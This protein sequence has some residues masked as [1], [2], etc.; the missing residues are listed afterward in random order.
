MIVYFSK[1]VKIDH[2][3]SKKHAMEINEYHWNQWYWQVDRLSKTG[4][5]Y[6]A[7]NAIFWQNFLISHSFFG[8]RAFIISKHYISQWYMPMEP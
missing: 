1:N 2:V 5:H 8:V 7:Q 3:T 6:A 4:V